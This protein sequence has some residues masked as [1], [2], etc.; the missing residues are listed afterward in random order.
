VSISRPIRTGNPP[1]SHRTAHAEAL[2]Y[3]TAIEDKPDPNPVELRDIEPL[4]PLLALKPLAVLSDID[5]TLALI[6]PDPASAGVTERAAAALRTLAARGVRIGFITGRSSDQARRMTG[7]PEASYATNHGLTLSLGGDEMTPPEVA[8][9]AELAVR[10]LA[11]IGSIDIPGVMIEDKG[12]IL[13]IHYRNAPSETEALT[14]IDAALQRSSASREFTRHA[15]RKVIELRPPLPL[16]KG[17]AATAMLAHLSPAAVVCM[18][19]DLTDVDLFDAV[20]ASNIRSAIVAVWNEEQQQ[21]MD[22]ADYF[23]RGVGG[24]E[25]LLEGILAEIT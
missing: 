8:R 18:G 15:A 23:V 16:N 6:V 13:A 12:P 4:R 25:A 3:N 17:T 1:N 2:Q 11:E 14:A 24:V 5:G 20:R 21:V 9:Y 22:A 10:T 19:D 7:I